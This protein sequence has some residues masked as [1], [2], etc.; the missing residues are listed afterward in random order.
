MVGAECEVSFLY[1]AEEQA[2]LARLQEEAA[3][4]RW[5]LGPRADHEPFL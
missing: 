1:H 2:R 4:L 3:W 5:G